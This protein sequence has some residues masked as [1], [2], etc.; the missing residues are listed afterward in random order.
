MLLSILAVL[1]AP[2]VPAESGVLLRHQ[3]EIG[4]SFTY[5]VSSASELMMQQGEAEQD[6]SHDSISRKTYRVVEQSDGGAVLELTIDRVRM[7]AN[8]PDGGKIV[9]DSTKEDVPTEFSHV[10][11]TIGPAVA[12]I[13]IDDRGRVVDVEDLLELGTSAEHFSRSN[14]HTLIELPEERVSA[15]SS[16]KQK[17]EVVIQPDPELPA[18]K[19]FQLMRVYTVRSISDGRVTIDWKSIA[20]TPLSDPAI[21]AQ[22]AH[23]KLRGLIQFDLEAG[24]VTKRTGAVQS[25]IVGFDGPQS[26]LRKSVRVA[27]TLQTTK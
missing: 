9:Y 27:E 2:G 11:A 22:V 24:R 25:Q 15:G 16:W 26:L 7:T 19:P 20:L 3:F 10:A 5:E 14:Q 21:E 8:D 6:L 1:L 13:T 17:F 4:Q 12:R 23:M 18:K